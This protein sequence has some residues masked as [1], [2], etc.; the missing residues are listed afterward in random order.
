MGRSDATRGIV[1][2]AT[3]DLYVRLARRAAR[4][5]RAAMP[6]IPIDL[7][8][9]RPLDDAIFDRVHL[10]ESVTVRPKMEA[11]RRS[12][13]DLTLFLDCDVIVLQALDDVFD[14]IAVA[15]VVAAHH[16]F[17]SAPVSMRTVR[18]EIPHA[19]RQINSGV[20]GIRRSPATDALLEKWQ[21]DFTA[22][23]QTTDQP[24]L[25]EMLFESDL[26]LIVLPPEYNLMYQPWVRVANGLM[27]APRLLHVPRLHEV[28][29]HGAT[30]DLPFN[31]AEVVTPAVLQKLGEL[32]QSDRTL[33]AGRDTRTY[34]AERLHDHPRLYRIYR[35]VRRLFA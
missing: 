23:K 1:F 22:L 18:R 11:L 12:R 26:R 29:E 34:A 30:P 27:M 6:D 31:P 28:P 24:L 35:R 19:F 13:F 5:V 7:F 17:G 16:Q 15:D 21:A 4:N 32:A 8:T 10:L 33:G 2:G 20:L 25:R 9:D 14:C 3:G